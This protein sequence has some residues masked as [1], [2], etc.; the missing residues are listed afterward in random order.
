M[1]GDFNVAQDKLDLG[2]V[3][4]ATSGNVDG[5]NSGLTIGGNTVE[6]HSVTNGMATFYG[7][8]SFTTALTLT[9][10]ANV[11]AAVQ[12]LQG[13]DIGAAGATIAFT[14]TIDGT[15]HTFI[16]RQGGDN[17]G[18]GTL[19][20][21]QGVTLTNLNTLIGGAV[22]PIVIDLDHNGYKFS[23]L[24]DGVQ[25]DINADGNPDQIAWNTSNDGILAYDLDGSGKIEDG[26]ELFTPDFG[27]GSFATGSAA[28]ASLD[29]N[30]DDMIDSDDQAFAN[31]VIWKDADADGVSDEGEL[32]SFGENGI[33]GISATTH[34]VDYFIDGQS[35][36][37][38]GTF[39]HTDGSTGSYVE[40]AL[41][42]SLGA[43]APDASDGDDAANTGGTV[44]IDPAALSDPGAADVVAGDNDDQGDVIDLTAL[45]DVAPSGDIGGAALDGNADAGASDTSGIGDASNGG[46]AVVIDADAFA[47]IGVA[48]LIADYHGDQGEAI[49]LAALLDT[50][51]GG[52]DVGSAQSVDAAGAASA[53][54]FPDVAAPSVPQ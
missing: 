23:S 53:A 18:N 38:E 12:Y 8:D 37:G 3:V 4:A 24:G 36:I 6:S 26:S 52:G 47:G 31:L 30:G 1:I 21:L 34:V 45:V 7:T 50:A 51:P 22:D 41:D 17:S 9:S 25:F 2:T 20:E 16:Y 43:S 10:I 27:G 42:T 32:S 11:A 13:T 39:H 5:S 40:V 49:D 15:D 29:S 46:D 54:S 14:A 28:L 35:I 33:E 48:D 19:V 44:G